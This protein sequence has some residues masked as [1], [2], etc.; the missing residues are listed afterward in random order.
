MTLFADAFQTVEQLQTLELRG[1]VSQVQG[2]TLRVADLAVPV[3]AM[4]EVGGHAPSRGRG[5]KHGKAGVPGQVVGF[6]RDM[7]LV[8]LL[9]DTLG[10][11]RGDRVVVTHETPVARVGHE[12]LGRV[13]DAMGRPIDG[14]GPIREPS[15]RPLT[16]P[17]VDPMHRVP[18]DQ[19]LGTGV[20]AIDA[21]LTVGRGQRLGIFSGPGVGK[22]TLLG[23]M[24]RQTAADVSVVAMIGE[25]GREV[26]D[27]VEKA[28]GPEG[29]ARSVVVVATADEPALMRIRAAHM[30][31]SVAEFYRDAGADVVLLM[32]SVTRFAQAQRQ[33]GLAAGEPPATKGYTPSVF[34][35]MPTLLER[36]GRTQ[37]GSVTGFYTILVEGD[38][39]DEPISDTAR[40]ILDGHVVLNRELG[41][42]GHWPAIDVLQSIS[43]VATDII[44][45]DHE[46]ART[47]TSRMINS[48]LEV[49]ELLNIGAYARGSNPEFDVAIEAKPLIDRLLQ[50]AP[51]ERVSFEQSKQMLMAVAQQLVQLTSKARAGGV[52]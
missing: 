31:T 13:I 46:A 30:A 6:D 32:D 44:E 45:P 19:P 47:Q 3:G 24:A 22:S 38:D 49:E 8:M 1:T 37:Q 23:M 50:Q 41:T 26:R 48:Y 12:L 40:G 7:A 34:A 11:R 36:S 25:R 15:A 4:V 21:M 5:S 9:G 14:L 29:L 35:A 39:M 20:R 42:K 52:S 33:V 10:I 28:L 43:R 17:P 18:I 51:G 27:F 16:P 2:L